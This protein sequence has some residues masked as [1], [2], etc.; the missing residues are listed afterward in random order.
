MRSKAE[1]MI[2]PKTWE[3][4]TLTISLSELLEHPKGIEIVGETLKSIDIVKK[5]MRRGLL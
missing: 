1:R 2:N 4:Y 5:T 3:D